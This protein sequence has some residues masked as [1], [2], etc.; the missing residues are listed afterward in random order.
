MET[1]LTPLEFARRTRHLHGSRE[2]VVDGDLRLSYE[3]FFDRCDRWSAALQELG[4]AQGDRVATIAPN[5]HTHLESFYSVPQIGAVLVPVNYRLT[6]EDFVYIVNHSGAT[7]LCVDRDYLDAVDKVREQMPAVRHFVAFEGSG[8]GWLDY[9]AAIAAAGPGFARPEISELDL[10]T[11]NYTSGTT[12]R[13]KGVMITHR[14]AAINTIGT[15]VH[16]PM[17]VGERYLWTLPMFHANGW[18]YTW[19]VT[20]AAGTHI[21]LRKIDAETVFNLIRE[22]RVS[23]LCAAPTVLIS[24]ANASAE[25]RGD[26]PAGVH[27]VAAGAA[28]AA[29]TIERLEGELGWEVTQ[30]YGLT[31]TSPFITVCIPLPEHQGLG[32]GDRAIVK[33]RQGVELVTSGELRVIDESGSEVPAD[34][35]S[36][37]EIV[38]RGNA[39]MHGYYRDPEATQRA[40]GDGW[41]H[42]G[43]AAV[44]HPDGY[45]EIRDRLKDV[46]ISGGENISSVEV[47]GALLRHPAVS[48]VAIVGLRHAK[49]GE[50]PQAFIVLR[51]GA[52]ATEEEMITFARG[53]LAHFKAPHGVTFVEELPKTAT[54]KIQKFVLREGAPNLTPQ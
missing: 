19:T 50:A 18:T 12:A 40:M 26:V 20:A 52:S 28:P 23:W 44:L 38:V 22:E 51:E 35:A 49:W 16:L 34:A 25:V 30:V 10:L 42:S 47:E 46:I 45:I 8:D 5:T 32:A 31:E 33:A 1:P 3:Q 15:L 9:E 54:G 21:C 29:A 48:E 41:F 13:P 27:V 17:G 4:V 2:A 7:V 53:Q 37:G 36:L 39:V 6:P 43:D 24:L 14:N 11:I